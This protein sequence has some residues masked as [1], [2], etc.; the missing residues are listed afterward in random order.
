MTIR[1]TLF[2]V[3]ISELVIYSN[4]ETLL[5]DSNEDDC[6]SLT[7]ESLIDAG[8]RRF[9]PS[10][11]I[12]FA[13]SSDDV[14]VYVVRH[15]KESWELGVIDDRI[16]K[17]AYISVAPDWNWRERSLPEHKVVAHREEWKDIYVLANPRE[18]VIEW[19]PKTKIMWPDHSTTHEKPCVN[20]RYFAKKEHLVI[21]TD[22]LRSH[23]AI[24]TEGE[25]PVEEKLNDDSFQ[26]LGINC[27]ESLKKNLKSKLI[28]FEFNHKALE[29]SKTPSVLTHTDIINMGDAE[30][31]SNINLES[32]VE[33]TLKMEHE[34]EL[35]S[36]VTT[37]WGVSGSI[38]GGWVGKFLDMGVS[39][40]A[41]YNSQDLRSNLTKTGKVAFESKKKLF[42]F[43]E[44]ISVPPRTKMTVSMNVIPVGGSEPYTATY[45]LSG[46]L[47][48]TGMTLNHVRNVLRRLGFK[49]WNSISQN[50]TNLD[51]TY[52]VNG[53]VNVD[54]GFN[55]HIIVKSQSLD[56]P[57]A[58]RMLRVS[59]IGGTT[60]LDEPDSRLR[61]STLN[62]SSVQT[63][64]FK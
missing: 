7:W 63:G 55:T 56:N 35:N 39:V 34:N 43:E 57:S 38:D 50:K 19:L 27:R 45:R 3:I 10:T 4:A 25:T 15:S 40:D 13:R 62:D 37:K 17:P 23:L 21:F 42:K 9:I 2:I 52:V 60:D 16:E 48:D 20:R 59:S 54:T 12:P 1:D 24:D 33:S 22:G 6:C 44:K 11:A 41:H 8:D 49:E 53:H 30:Q 36:V 28:H 47:L 31:E 58:T 18:C 64:E 32:S 14:N 51:I 26:V 61:G 46:N 29:K 5:F